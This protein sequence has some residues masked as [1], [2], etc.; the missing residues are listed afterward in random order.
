M[1]GGTETRT[2]KRKEY[3]LFIGRK[4]T[5][6]ISCTLL[7]IFLF[8]IAASIGSSDMTIFKA[9]AAFLQRFF[10][11]YIEY[12]WAA[13]TIVWNIRLPRILLGILAGISFGVTGALMQS[14]LRNPLA[15][16]YTLGVSAGA[17]FGAS[18][19]IL[20]G[21]GVVG[22]EYMIIVNAFI[23]AMLSSL[24]I[25]SLAGKKGATP[26]TM[27][28]SGIAILYIFSACTSLL[29][30]FGNPEAVKDVVFWTV[31]SL[32]KASWNAVCFLF[33]VNAICIP[34]LL[35]KSWDLNVIASGDETARSIGVNVKRVRIVT[36]LV[37]SFLVAST[38]SFTGTI[39]FIGLVA[40][41]IARIFV[42]GDNRYLLPSS[43]LV[44][45]VFL[46]AADTASRTIIAPTIIPVGITTAFIGGPLFMYLIM[47]RRREYF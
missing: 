5:F 16:P 8:G 44:G 11:E 1:T 29:Q 4:V 22:G 14:V 32:G 21:F 27:I 13:H 24:V 17:A 34:I 9:Y 2:D 36:L 7:L 15:S 45:A 47:K 35:I 31:G 42:G 41:H 19:G 46:L 39:G 20:L 10:P 37:A 28:L 3:K 26:E 30:Y 23:F 12:S 43:C 6:I 25:I 33:I 38:V 40:P 18:I